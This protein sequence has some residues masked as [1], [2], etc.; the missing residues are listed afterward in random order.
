MHASYGRIVWQ[1]GLIADVILGNGEMD[2]PDF[3]FFLTN[4]LGLLQW[5][6]K[7]VLEFP[8]FLS[9]TICRYFRKFDHEIKN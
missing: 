6:D 8:I 5:L 9:F 1:E 4:S 7:G 3:S 2:L